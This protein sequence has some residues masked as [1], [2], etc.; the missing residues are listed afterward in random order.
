MSCNQRLLLQRLAV[1]EPEA[2][3]TVLWQEHLAD[4]AECRADRYALA[5]SL[6]VFRQF[7][8]QPA[9]V[10]GPS[11]EKFSRTLE[12]SQRRQSRLFVRVPLAA[13]SLLVAVSTGVLF[14]PVAEQTTEQPRPAR[15]V[16]VQPSQRQQMQDVLST[17]LQGTAAI[18][19]AGITHESAA[20]VQTSPVRFDLPRRD[21]ASVA[22]VPVM[23]G[24]SAA[25]EPAAPSA[26]PRIVFGS[27]DGERAPVLLF[28]SLQQQQ[29]GRQGP[30]QVMPVFSPAH[31]DS[32]SVLPRALL[33][34]LPIR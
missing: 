5:R 18:G 9:A 3:E 2:L 4:C 14:W 25:A 34:P 23:D 6:A 11:W 17:S 28:R 15:I 21:T 22:T 7:E 32:G 26:G 8:S 20:P 24:Q 13:A 12:R 31:R 27:Q 30:F 1:E 10:S 16:T 19:E 29:R 33:S